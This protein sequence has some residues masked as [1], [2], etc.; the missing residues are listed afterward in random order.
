MARRLAT[1]LLVILVL[2]GVAAVGLVVVRVP[3][4]QA[5]LL[6]VAASAGVP[7][8]GLTVEAVGLTQ[9]EIRDLRLG[10]DE[11]VTARAL[12]VAF[13]PED[14]IDGR[15]EGVTADGLTLHLDLTG[16]GPLLG[17]LQPLLGAGA[18]G[19]P[20]APPP[21]PPLSLRGATVRAKTPLGEVAAELDGDIGPGIDRLAAADLAF[22]LDGPPGR[23]A[24][25]LVLTATAD[26]DA[27][28]SMTITDG[29]LAL[30]AA[31]I[32]G[33]TGA[34]AFSLDD[35]RPTA[36][37]G[38]LSAGAVGVPGA[39][40]KDARIDVRLANG[41]LELA[42][43]LRTADDWAS[44]SVRAVLDDITAASDLRL[45]AG[46]EIDARTDLWALLA[47]PAP[48]SGRAVLILRAEGRLPPLDRL[49]AAFPPDA[50][51]W[52][53]GPLNGLVGLDMTGVTYP[54]AAE[55]VAG[56][57]SVDVAVEDGL[58]A[59]G[60]PREGRLEANHVDPAWLE[61]IG[62]PAELAQALGG[63]AV[64]TVPALALH[65]EPGREGIAVGLDGAVR[66]SAGDAEADA[67]VE[68]RFDLD[69]Q[70]ALATLDLDGLRV[71]AREVPLPGAR[72]SDLRLDG[73]L[74]GTPD[75]LTGDLDLAIALAEAT[76]GDLRLADAALEAPVRITTDGETIRATL[77]DDGSI[78]V[79]TLTMA[80]TIASRGPWRARLSSGEVTAAPDETGRLAVAHR[81]VLGTGDLGLTV[82]RAGGDPL[83]VG[84]AIGRVEIDGLAQGSDY[85][86]RVALEDARIS[87][88]RYQVALGN[89]RAEATVDTSA[90]AA[91]LLLTGA[92]LTH[93]AAAPVFAPLDLRGEARRA[94]SAVD[95]SAESP[96]TD[97]AVWLSLTGIHDLDQAS[98]QARV[99]VG[100]LSFAADGL[101]PAAVLPVLADLTQVS[102]R[103]GVDARLEWDDAGVR[104]TADLD[105]AGLSFQS[106]GTT[107]TDLSLALRLDQLLPPASA[108]GQRLTVGRIDA[109][110]P[111]TDLSVLFRVRPGDTPRLAIEKGGLAVSGG[112]LTVHDAVIDP[113]ATRQGVDLVVDGLDLAELFR[114]LEIEGL[115][116][117]G[118][119]AGLLPIAFTD[120]RV[121]IANGRLDALGPGMVRYRSEEAAQVL[122][123]AGKSAELLIQALQN[124]QYDELSMTVDKPEAGDARLA[125]K[126]LGRNPDV[127][128]GYPFRLNVNLETDVDKI[129]SALIEANRLSNE[130]IRRAWTLGQ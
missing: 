104:G 72:V 115:S 63:G 120:G 15:I 102:G 121:T 92:T 60:L 36:V 39:A 69:T 10:A 48:S 14:L 91:R 76:A 99:A 116:A 86:A 118:S 90:Q 51:R 122:G 33:L 61:A 80:E 31:E 28:G 67:A 123:S 108:P 129:L 73:N 32:A 130:V 17:S 47:L 77:K 2:L 95:V 113:A 114:G 126:L 125:L 59:L 55:G 57:V 96:G 64:L 44:A 81:L 56:D 26:L 18:K 49:A 3:L 66:L 34:A 46:A 85:S 21:L 58:L 119:I 8:P 7:A 43:D 53:Q 16:D 45:D 24:G 25:R 75:R 11:E 6:R 19:E 9:V 94:G 50:A 37:D 5:V 117:T 27:D 23:V 110:V 22:R 103:A 65:A 82:R 105:L 93:L 83:E 29:A 71:R 70:G 88:A 109:G 106:A 13:T 124:F 40:F 112:R 74:S 12:T 107:V 54:G 4:L 35:G 68:G 79:S 38:A 41:R 1:S 62:V 20:A 89:V 30:P 111:L 101:Q 52:P 97:G 87:E 42:G 84:A 98:G 127:L 78:R 128:D 100:P